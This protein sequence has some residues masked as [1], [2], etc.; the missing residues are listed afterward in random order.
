[1]QILCVYEFITSVCLGEKPLHVPFLWLNSPKQY[2]NRT[3]PYTPF[4][5]Y[6]LTTWP[7]YVKPLVKKPGPANFVVGSPGR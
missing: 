6:S 5:K 7:T 1:M 4:K 2:L 3:L